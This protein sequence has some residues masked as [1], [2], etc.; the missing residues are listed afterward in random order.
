MFRLILKLTAVVLL[1]LI[2]LD[3]VHLILARADNTYLQAK[4]VYAAQQ[5]RTA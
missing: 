3:A 1:T 5:R 4:L 2:L